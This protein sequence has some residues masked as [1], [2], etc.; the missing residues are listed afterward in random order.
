MARALSALALVLVLI[1]CAGP[2]TPYQ[3]KA[4]RTG[5]SQQQLDAQTWRV[6]FAGNIYTPRET[7][8]D[9]LL[10]RS[11]EIMLLG[12]YEKFVMLEKDIERNVEYW[13]TGYY[14][15]FGFGL[16]H[17]HRHGRH[18]GLWYDGPVYYSPL[19]RYNGTATIRIYYGGPPPNNAPVYDA[20]EIAQQ[21]GPTIVLPQAGS[22]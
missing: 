8:E 20:Q 17:G 14:P 9:Y 11:A 19:V 2:P 10:Y 18:H 21:L 3:P 5:Y 6:Q 15:H 1:G 16:H 13:G 22:G 12:G 7:V 4:D